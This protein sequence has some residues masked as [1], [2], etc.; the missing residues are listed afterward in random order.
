YQATMLSLEPTFLPGLHLG[1]VRVQ[2]DT[3]RATRQSLAYYLSRVIETPFWDADGA[4]TDPSDRQGGFY[5]RWVLPESGFEAY[6]EWAR[7]DFPFS[8]VNLLYEPDY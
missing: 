7:E 6:L 2:N 5:A 3:A 4:G 8:F 1:L